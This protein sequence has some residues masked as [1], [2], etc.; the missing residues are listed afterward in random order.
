MLKKL[1]WRQLLST[2]RLDFARLHREALHNAPPPRRTA[3]PARPKTT[4]S[5]RASAGND[6]ERRHQRWR[7]VIVDFMRSKL[8]DVLSYALGFGSLGYLVMHTIAWIRP[9]NGPSMLPTLS[10]WSPEA[11][12][13]YLLV[14]YLYRRGR[15]IHVGDI[16]SFWHPV[17]R[18]TIAM[19]RVVAMPGDFVLRDTPG[20]G[21]GTLIQVPQGHCWVAGDNLE[22]SRDS[23]HFGPL[24]LALIRGKLIARV[25]PERKVFREGLTPVGEPEVGVQS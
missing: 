5:P 9:A 23:R 12:C 10:I 3:A 6:Q 20:Q 13:D 17:R 11:G 22:W 24:P 18:G 14:S 7:A 21:D 19:K 15:D 1:Q 16:V 25:R 8:Y 4:P 2:R